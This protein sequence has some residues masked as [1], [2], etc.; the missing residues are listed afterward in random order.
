MI[1]T[2]RDHQAQAAAEEA[3]TNKERIFVV[4]SAFIALHAGVVFLPDSEGTAQMIR[5]LDKVLETM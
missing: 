4:R 3:M 5:F 2:N 1:E